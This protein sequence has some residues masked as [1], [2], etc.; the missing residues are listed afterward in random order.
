MS[1]LP[2]GLFFV[3]VAAAGALAL[4]VGAVAAIDG[5]YW[6]LPLALGGAALLAWSVK[7]TRKG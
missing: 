2:P 1:R 3:V 4:G 6:G 7:A 5:N